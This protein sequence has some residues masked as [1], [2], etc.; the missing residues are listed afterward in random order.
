M[1]ALFSKLLIAHLVGDFIVFRNKRLKEKGKPLWKSRRLIAHALIHFIFSWIALSEVAL[2]PF[3]LIIGISHYASE[4]IIRNGLSRRI[5]LAFITDQ[6]FHLLLIY[7]VASVTTDPLWPS[8]IMQLQMPWLSIAGLIAV[9]FP[10]AKFIEV[11][12]SQWPP[13]KSADKIKGLTNAGLW[14]GILERILIYLFIITGHWEGIGFLLAA[15]SI[16]RF[17]DL[18]NSK[19]ISLTEYIMVGT[20]LSFC[21]AIVMGLTINYL[22]YGA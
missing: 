18:T 15:K 6:L 8:D 20:L 3:A 11:F 16:F 19:D 7:I 13:A 4:L 1:I 5:Q 21:T 22:S 10:A 2:W 14:I 12:L 9:T 17:G